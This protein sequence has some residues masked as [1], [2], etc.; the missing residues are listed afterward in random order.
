[1]LEMKTPYPPNSMKTKAITRAIAVFIA[2]D[3]RPLSVVDRLA[4]RNMVHELDPQYKLPTRRHFTEKVMPQ[5]Y[6]EVRTVVENKIKNAQ[7]I[8]LTTDSWTSR[9]CES[10]IAVTAHFLTNWVP[11]SF[12]LATR[13]LEESHTG[14]NIG[15]A[16]TDIMQEFKIN[17]PSGTALVTDNAANIDIA[18][19]TAGLSPHIKCFAHTVNI[20][21]QKGVKVEAMQQLLSKVRRVVTFFHKSPT[22]TAV[23]KAKQEHMQLEKHK[24][25]ND[26][27]TRWNSTFEMLE[28]FIEQQ[29]A[30]LATLGSTEIRK[31]AKDLISLSADD[32]NDLETEVLRPL[33]T[34][35]AIMCD[36]KIQRSP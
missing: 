22:A 36:E 4:F 10:Y 9:A 14:V 1:M 27:S 16:L 33:K 24:L 18:S 28:R 34:I 7:H 6:A 30:I 35:T 11:H 3:L 8:A 21:C 31:N 19:R 29:P 5:L 26:V 20:A 2:G 32:M 25:I 23:L 17:R 12:V 15:N 13:I